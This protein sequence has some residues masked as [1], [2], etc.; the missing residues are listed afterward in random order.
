M[1]PL[2]LA[3]TL[4]LQHYEILPSQLAAP[5]ATSSV[6]NG[7][8]VVAKPA[9]AQLLLPTGYTISKFATGL[10]SPRYMAQAPNGDVFVIE[11]FANRVTVLRDTDQDGVADETYAFVRGLQEPFGIAFHDGYLYIGDTN[12]V[13]RYTY[14]TDQT[15]AKGTPETIATLPSGG[16]HS[17]RNLVF[18]A[19]GG[20]LYAGVGSTGNSSPESDPRRAAI[21]QMNPDG[22][23][24]RIYATGLR[25]PSGLAIEPVT[26]ALWTTVNERDGLGDDLVPDYA[27]SVADG[28][29][30][31]WPYSYIGKNIDPTLGNQKPDLVATAVV[32]DVLFQAHSAALGMTFWKGDAYVAMHGSWNRS[33]RTGYKVVRIR[34]NGGKPVGGYDDFVLGWSQDETSRNVWGRPVGLLVMN[35]G[36]LLISDDGANVIWRVTYTAPQRRRAAH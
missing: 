25:N 1:F 23:S 9:G 22:S 35:D 11:T 28:A 19:S 21:L 33:R 17:L 20:K 10:S 14:T 12:A 5:H 4:T 27:T 3:A 31:G 36:S 6:D 32:P 8:V 29:F 16:S 18:D 30:Y 26:G 34:M 15:S 2:L 7:P 24:Q 13:L